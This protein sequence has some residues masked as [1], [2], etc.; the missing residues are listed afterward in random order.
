MRR[1]ECRLCRW[2]L[3]LVAKNSAR[4]TVS[5]LAGKMDE[6]EVGLAAV[7]KGQRIETDMD[8]YV[9]NIVGLTLGLEVGTQEGIGVSITDGG[10]GRDAEG[11]NDGIGLGTRI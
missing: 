1:L 7:R 6:Q 5:S 2:L 11:A 4:E 3:R 8:R 9:G 10:L